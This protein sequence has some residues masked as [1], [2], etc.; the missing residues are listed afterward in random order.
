MAID[1]DT[2]QRDT[3]VRA[4]DR[5]WWDSWVRVKGHIGPV[6]LAALLVLAAMPLLLALV[7][8]LALPGAVGP[9]FPGIESLR[10]VGVALNRTLSLAW[11]PPGDRETI[12][13]L[14]LLPTGALLIALARL[15]FGL[16]VLG[17]RAILVGIGF[18][19]AGF[20]PGLALLAVVVALTI[21]IR[22]GLR[23]IRLPLYARI[24]VILC[25]AVVVMVAALL[26]GPSLGSAALWNV[27][28]FPVII[29]AMLAEGIARTLAN[30]S[31]V[32]AAWRAA[33]TLVLAVLIALI[34]ESR[35]ISELTLHFPELLLTQV[36]AIVLVA[37]FLDLRLLEHWPSRLQRLIAGDTD[38]QEEPPRLA[39]VRNRWTSGVIGRLGQAAPRRYRK[40]SVQR[41]VDALRDLG[42]ETRV[43]EAD[44]SLL[45]ALRDF[46]PPEPRS[47]RPGGL[48]LNLATGIQGRGRFGHVPAILEMAGVAYTGPDPLAHARLS[49]RYALLTLLA[50]AGL[51]VP[52]FSLATAPGDDPGI[53]FPRVL[54]PR[55]EPDAP[56]RSV[57]DVNAYR[58]ALARMLDDSGEAV[59]IEF[60]PRGRAL[61]AILVGNDPVECLPLVEQLSRPRRKACPAALGAED[62]VALRD[63]ACRAFRVAGCRDVARVDLC[64]SPDGTVTVMDIR[65]IDLFAR[66]GSLLRAA[67]AAGWD[68]AD[69]LLKIL[70]AAANRY[71]GDRADRPAAAARAEA[72][73]RLRAQGG[74]A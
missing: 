72:P 36:V 10:P 23:R 5:P 59:V 48:V 18:Q 74:G 37:E 33:W 29:V 43:L 70:Q 53:D 20:G 68:L 3:R 49:D 15:T 28:F 62:D 22:P 4:A 61:R 31:A 21:A 46:L 7:K 41:L 1:G 65:S 50:D 66:R 73:A 58:E 25:L 2:A 8:V 56:Q 64:L 11:V 40:R 14:L 60:R 67:E 47:G 39:V 12:M 27:A 26:L 17:L 71:A 30:D 57:D 19:I 45:P 54:R 52:P 63:T 42:F 9:G 38:W 24:T 69:L 32:T 51:P 44:M 6:T 35:A 34:G 16:R 13:Y 55:A